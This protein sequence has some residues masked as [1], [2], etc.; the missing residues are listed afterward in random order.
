[1]ALSLTSKT[2]PV[3]GRLRPVRARGLPRPVPVRV[4]RDH[5]RRLARG[6]R[7]D[8][9]DAG[10]GRDRRRDRRRAGAGRGRFRAG[11]ARVPRG[12]ARD[13]RPRGDPARS[14]TRC[15]P[16]SARTGKM[17]AIEH[18]GVE[19]DLMTLAK[20]IAAGLPLS[21]VVGKAEIMDCLP[22][23]LRR[24]HVRRQSGRARGCASPS[25]TC[26]RRRTSSSARSGSARRSARGCSRGR[27]A[28]TRSATCAG[29]A[30]CS[31]SSTSRIA[32]RRSRRRRSRHASPRRPRSAGCSC[33]RPASTRTA[34]ASSVPLVITD[35]EL[36][37]ALGAWED[38]LER[39]RP[40]RVAVRARLS[41]S[42]VETAYRGARTEV[43]DAGPAH[44][45]PDRRPL[46]AR[47]DRR[48]RR[49]VDRLPRARH[50]A[51]AA[52]RDQDPPRALRGRRRVRRALP[53]RGAC[54]R[55]ARAPKHRHRHRPRRGRGAASTSS[56]SSSTARTSRS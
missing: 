19:P 46:R 24:R 12:R 37:E 35:A 4:P 13:L 47:G 55:A 41:R 21:A 28:T 8:A 49:H 42:F 53:P 51:R 7:A 2:H 33:S 29:S 15:R 31:R 43:D 16:D 52:R 11:A 44:R 1:M 9:L 38:A 48:Q 23:Q 10:R 34:T 39:R 25:S 45:R 17:F 36:E 3:Q 6:A 22:G 54:R 20:S 14:S 18:S 27:S 50:A 5:G 26:S 40:S 32:R 56:S 30:R